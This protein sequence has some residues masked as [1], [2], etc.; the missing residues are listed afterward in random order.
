[1][2]HYLGPLGPRGVRASREMVRDGVDDGDETS[3][4]RGRGVDEEIWEGGGDDEDPRGREELLVCRGVDCEVL[5]SRV[6][7]AEEE[8]EGW[9]WWG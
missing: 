5:V 7:P 6:G 9:W 4:F 8:D 1:M 2:H 3:C